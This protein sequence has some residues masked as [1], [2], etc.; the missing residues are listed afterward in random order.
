MRFRLGTTE[1]NAWITLN[2]VS[3]DCQ[4]FLS[5]GPTRYYLRNG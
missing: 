1:I 4:K 2:G 5:I 3:R